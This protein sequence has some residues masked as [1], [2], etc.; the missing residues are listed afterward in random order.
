MQS[1]YFYIFPNPVHGEIISLISM[2]MNMTKSLYILLFDK[3]YV[4]FNK[5]CVKASFLN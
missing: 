4:K 1:D 5:H 3:V 2:L